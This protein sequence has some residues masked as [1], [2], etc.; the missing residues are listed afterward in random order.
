MAKKRKNTQNKPIVIVE[1][2]PED[3]SDILLPGDYEVLKERY[4]DK[5]CTYEVYYPWKDHPHHTGF[6]DDVYEK[7]AETYT[8]VRQKSE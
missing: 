4:G 6:V 1:I 7:Y 2:Y 8:I 5:P 3:M